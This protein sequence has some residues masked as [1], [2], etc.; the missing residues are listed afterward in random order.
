MPQ[1][2]TSDT[3]NL[4]RVLEPAAVPGQSST[5]SDFMHQAVSAVQRGDLVGALKHLEDVV[6]LDPSRASTLR[7]ETGL[8]QIGAHVERLVIHLESL[9]GS[10][11][12]GRLA[13]A[14]KML[15]SWGRQPLPGWDTAPQTLLTLANQLYG[16]GGYLNFL[17]ADSLAQV[18]IEG[19][20]VPIETLRADLEASRRASAASQLN[21]RLRALWGRAPLLI[22]LVSWFMLG[23]AATGVAAILHYFW[24]EQFPLSIIDSGFA[25]WGIGF[26][27]LI[28]F[29][30]YM[31]VRHVRFR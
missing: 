27:V 7:A 25:L 16:A 30:F 19:T 2:A 1:I 8:E 24:P 15:E 10:D 29:G 23:L 31:R 26:L 20:R 6:R 3:A 18:L 9:A 4:M 5:V 12:H 21:H 11:A 28:A 14:S 22:L 13:E 17:R